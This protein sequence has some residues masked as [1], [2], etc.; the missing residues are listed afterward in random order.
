LIPT[1]AIVLAISTLGVGVSLL[2][3]NN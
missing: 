3:P 1:G 2:I